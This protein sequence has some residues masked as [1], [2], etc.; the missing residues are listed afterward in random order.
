MAT[1]RREQ[2]VVITVDD[3][4]VPKRL[5]SIK[6]SGRRGVGLMQVP[7]EVVSCG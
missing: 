5:S 6:S 2:T 1:P 7:V 3:L 4:F